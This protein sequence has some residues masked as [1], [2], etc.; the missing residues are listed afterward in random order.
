MRVVD[1]ELFIGDEARPIYYAGVFRR[2]PYYIPAEDVAELDRRR[3]WWRMAGFAIFAATIAGA[4]TRRWNPWWCALGI[5]ALYLGPL[6]VARWVGRRYEHVSD[7]S[8]ERD[9]AKA[10]GRL[11]PPP[12]YVALMF[13]LSAAQF[14]LASLIDRNSIDL[15]LFALMSVQGLI[16]MAVAIR[17][18]RIVGDDYA[19]PPSDLT[20]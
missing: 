8:I 11:G 4:L 2:S 15:V 3:F 1:G 9:V 18:R 19:P 5:L 12:G 13:A 17:N 16:L 10:A 14:L 7:P 6:S 20:R